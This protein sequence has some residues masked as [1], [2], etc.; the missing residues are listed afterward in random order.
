MS[1]CALWYITQAAALIL[2]QDAELVRRSFAECGCPLEA[3]DSWH[4]SIRDTIES[5]YFELVKTIEAKNTSSRWKMMRKSEILCRLLPS[6]SANCLFKTVFS[7]SFACKL[8][9][10][11][12]LLASCIAMSTM[13]SA[14]YSFDDMR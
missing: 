13:L 1:W 6:R 7:Y 2:A 14:I 5:S 10:T 11:V 8:F 4:I 3:Q 9:K 12:T